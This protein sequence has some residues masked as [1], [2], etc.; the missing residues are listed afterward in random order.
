MRTLATIL[1]VA[2]AISV[3]DA[4]TNVSGTISKDSTWSLAG[5]PYMVT[6]SVTV[7]S[8]FTLTVDS[9]V[10][11]LFQP[12]TNLYAYGN[13][14]AR[15]AIFTSSKDTAGGSPQKGD[16]GTIQ[17]GYYASSPTTTFDTCQLKFGGANGSSILYLQ[18]GTASLEGCTIT[19]SSTSDINM[20]SGSLS[21]ANSNISNATNIGITFN[22]TAVN[23]T[24]VTITSCDWPL[25]YNGTV[26]L[27]FNGVNAL[28]G[29]HHNGI[30]MNFGSCNTMT[31]DTVSIPYV[32][33]GDFSVNA[34]ATLTIA[35]GNIL[36]FNY[37]HLYVNGALY[38]V[39]GIGQSIY[40]TSYKNDNLPLGNGDTNADGSQTAPGQSDWSGVYF[41]SSSNDSLSVMRRCNVTFAGAG[42]IGGITLDNSGPTVDSCSMANNYYGA[43][44]IGTANPVFSNNDIGTS[45]VVP[46]AMSFSANP[47]FTNNS[48]SA[49]DNR[50]DAI[51]LLG[52]TLPADAVLPIRSVTSVPNV[53]Y[54]MLDN[55]TIPSGRTMTIKKAVVIKSFNG[56]RITV[57]GKLIANSTPDST[58]VFTSLSDDNYGNPH[59]TNKN[60][61]GTLPNVGDWGGIV[62]EAT[63]DTSSILNY[64]RIRYG[65]LPSSY[66][67]FRWIGGGEITTVQASPTISNCQLENVPYGVYS[68]LESYPKIWNDSITN[69]QYTPIALSVS[70]DPS[71]AGNI[72]TNTKW[73]ALGI[74]GGQVSANG[75][76][77]E[78][79]VAGFA[80]ITYVLLE[81]LSINSGT[82]VTVDPG[83]VIKSAGPGIY[84]DGGFRAK[85][86]I[87]GGQVVF[88]SMYDDNFGNPHDTNGDGN[89]SSPAAG[90]WSTIR[91]QATS[92]DTFCLLDS[93][94]IKFNGNSNWG[95]VTFTDAGGTVSNSTISD[96]RAFG[97]R[98]EG[99][100]TPQV[101]NV[102]IAN[103]SADPI[104]MSL[105]AN[106]TFTNIIFSANGSKGIHILEGTL[107]SNAVLARRDVAGI[108]NIAYIIDNLT[109]SPNATLTIAPGVVLKFSNGGAG[110]SVQGALIADGT[111]TQN[112]VFTS[113]RD[114]SNGGD[115]NNDGNGSSPG[116]GDWDNI[117]F[118]ASSADS[119]NV[120]RNCQLRYGG[121]GYYNYN[122][123]WGNIRVFNSQVVIDSCVIEQCA[124][125]AVGAFG[126]AHPTISNSQ[127]NNISQTPIT[128]S[129]FASPSFSNNSSLNIGYM[130]LG[131]V[132]ETYSVDA[133]VPVRN[134]GGF[135]NIT[136]L[137]YGTCTVN[138]G[139]TV[140]I[141]AGIVFKGGSFQVN[142]SL[143]VNGT[144]SQKV[145]FTDPR[146]DSYGNPHDTNGDGTSS[147]PSIQGF[148]R[149]S[150][151]DVSVDS[152]SAINNAMFRYTDGGIS[153]Q[154]AS[155]KILD[156]TFDEDNWGVYLDGVSNP[157]LD[158]CV[159]NNL[160][161][162][163]MRTSLV[164]YPSSTNG[165]VI[166][167]TTYKA[168]GVKEGETLVQNVTL[169]QHT[170]AGIKNIPYL[171]G[172]YTV[173]TNAVLTISPGVVIKFFPFT[174]MTIHKGLMAIGGA[175]PDSTIVFTDVRDDFY[176]GDSNADSTAT[177]PYSAYSGWSGITFADESLDPLC[178]LKHA[179]VRYAGLSYSWAAIT[180]NN[181][182]PTI[183]YSSIRDCGYGVVANGASNPVINYCD[184][185]HNSNLG[186]NNV[187][188]S[189]VIDAR[190]NWWGSNTGPTVASNPGGSGQTISVGVNYS[191]FL[192]TGAMNPLAGDVSLNGDIQ[193]YDAS[194]ILKWLA[195]STSNPLN[196][197][198]RSVADVSGNGSIMAYDAA[199]IL[200]YV[201]GRITLFPVELN[202]ANQTPQP[203]LAKQ[204]AYSSI[205]LSDNN[206]QRGQ[207]FTV[208][209]SASGLKNVLSAD[210]RLAFNKS[211]L[212]AVSVK[213]IGIAADARV[214]DNI[215]DGEVRIY[216]ASA[217]ALAS[218]GQ[219]LAVTFEA[220]NDVRGNVTSPITF[221]QF[222][223][224]EQDVKS[225]AKNSTVSIAGKPVSYSLEQNYPNPFN[226]TTTVAYQVPEDNRFVRIE[227]YNI[228][229]QHVRTLVNGIQNA[230]EYKVTWDGNDDQGIKV[231]S[232]VYLLRMQSGSFTQIRKMMLLK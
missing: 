228:T 15:Q 49:S 204:A 40:F 221:S 39:A 203:F 86:T 62:F 175:T 35:S 202:K 131:I 124:T 20:Y 213:P 110:I 2:L 48:F 26:P 90:N 163:P 123:N 156:C 87:A 7:G 135:T 185:Y 11:V 134:F 85:G 1:F 200:Q 195:D 174:G 231:G 92:N 181:A 32:F 21:V 67:Y 63:S 217:N 183:T 33:G 137:L 176:G 120:L 74:I 147:Q 145:I 5:S 17:I 161:Y 44:M 206:T 80:N 214:E 27:V 93:C 70:A 72:F 68:F 117:D 179:V 105:K 103:C 4:T 24:N 157:S 107:S 73:T 122:Y 119:L 140:T 182:S 53:T 227:I 65:S 111:A 96:S 109:I 196:D 115:T 166:S 57:Q 59:D 223:L 31:L 13:L 197:I 198:Q 144:P 130:A 18:Y 194:L 141:P 22:G 209:L 121:S 208:Y 23:L 155:P 42:N 29:N 81:D 154:Q 102:T 201:V 216:L 143:A 180:A 232:G 158:S 148:S 215:G 64:C 162:A 114:D 77:K 133:T 205:A 189:F 97:V 187:N 14:Q 218:D 150:F 28:T 136:Y 173:A 95:A 169:G 101:N 79:T 167:G 229:G 56:Y 178:Q 138:T 177:T 112:I 139:T 82:N 113:I 159:F 211:E 210:I 108:N 100:S 128:M 225:A 94:L 84:V 83:V 172:N 37:G 170:F 58:I 41:T 10:T 171:F 51:G 224:N 186:V 149:I 69:S 54:L 222:Y 212:R 6:G 9:G 193:A 3:A 98:C 164:S 168:L 89:A 142:G 219:I 129:M 43:M 184:I 47:V 50:Y 188:Q 199:L 25:Q 192:G 34:G 190:W 91:F 160:T 19:N 226:P 132:P 220:N 104:A 38:A 60:G 52:G 8:G 153:L 191:P 36:K 88:T 126:S 46:I 78:R 61:N 45:Y 118:S 152:L 12:G 207:E 66:Y 76:I 125:S 146:D 151:A 116:R 99:S 30:Y 106:P 127:L 16:W 71:F 75:T 230:G 55:V 165:D